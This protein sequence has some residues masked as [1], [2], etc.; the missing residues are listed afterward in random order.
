MTEHETFVADAR[1][2]FG[3]IAE[4]DIECLCLRIGQLRRLQ[5]ERLAVLALNARQAQ[6]IAVLEA[7]A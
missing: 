5:D 4:S 3:H 1:K 7:N 2:A 6:K